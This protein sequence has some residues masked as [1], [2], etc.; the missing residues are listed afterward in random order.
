MSKFISILKFSFTA[1]II[2]A[3][4]FGVG[5]GFSQYFFNVLRA[6]IPEKQADNGLSRENAGDE[7]LD[8]DDFERT[9]I[10]L[11]G[12][13][14]RQGEKQSRSDTMMLVSI[15]PELEKVAV[16]SIPRDTK[17]DVEGSSLDKICTA[18]FVG[19][20]EM[21]VRSVE[22]LLDID[23]DHYVVADFTGFEK[24]VDTLGG[25]TVNVK[26]RM[27]KAG[28]GI[29]LYPGVQRMD[30]KDA[31]AFVRYRDYS[32]GDIDRNS[33]QQ[34]FVR[35]LFDEL[36][37]AG[38]ITKLPVLA[39]QLNDYVETNWGIGDMVKIVSW[40][41]FIQNDAIVC[42]TLP[43][44]FYDERNNEGQVLQSYWLADKQQAG[45]LLDNVLAGKKV[46][47]VVG[48]SISNSSGT[49]RTIDKVEMRTD[50]E[51]ELLDDKNTELVKNKDNGDDNKKEQ[52]A[53]MDEINDD[54][55]KWERSQLLSSNGE[56][57]NE[58][59]NG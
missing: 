26:H 45:E 36:M 37:Q 7:L 30:G 17:V 18:N 38:T 32:L 4:C 2:F 23:I 8:G 24:I 55:W 31:L 25:V 51:I 58:I 14:A 15:D 43:G 59:N 41:P 1:I 35:A 48:N 21:A 39:M 22:N 52:L 9:N 57:Y 33:Q 47:A 11:L 49:K 20:P 46:A 42:Q 53:E 13:D 3:L 50:E 19:G 56:E 10:L 40:V 12:V 27:Y 28:E 6:D 29:D 34:E 54:E 44:Y 5:A 16:I